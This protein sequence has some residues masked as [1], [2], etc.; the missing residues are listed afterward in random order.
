MGDI[1]KG[2]RSLDVGLPEQFSIIE[3]L[4]EIATCPNND[5]SKC[6]IIDGHPTISPNGKPVAFH[7]C[8][9]SWG[10]ALISTT[11]GAYGLG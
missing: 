6:K 8:H 3:R 10:A 7:G 9:T 2:Y 1:K 11:S 5:D 4:E